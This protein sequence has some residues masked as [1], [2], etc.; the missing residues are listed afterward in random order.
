MTQKKNQKYC[1]KIQKKN[2]IIY[3]EKKNL[4][5]IK[6]PI[7]SQLLRPKVK[8]KIYQN[9]LEVTRN[10]SGIMSKYQRKKLCAVQG[11]TVALI[12]QFL[13]ETTSILHKKLN[14][15]GVG[16][17]TFEVKEHKNTLVMFR[18]G[19]SHPIFFKIP[20]NLTFFCLKFTKLYIFGNSYQT[21]NQTAS[22][23]QMFKNPEPYKGK[24]ILLEGEKIFLK[25]GKKV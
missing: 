9:S 14:F 21:I 4:L 17:R 23:I 24:G 20:K 3:N 22:K 11:A 7:K 13:V 25:E 5:V 19:Y 10:P 15:I 6:G 2:S 8:I 16:Y 12:K 18:L 1:I